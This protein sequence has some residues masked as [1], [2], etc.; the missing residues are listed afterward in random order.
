M[1]QTSSPDTL[2][3]LLENWPDEVTLVP[4]SGIQYLD[5]AFNIDTVMRGTM[6]FS[7]RVEPASE[8]QEIWRLW[9][10]TGNED[11]DAEIPPAKVEGEEDYSISKVRALEPFLNK[12]TP[13]P[14]L[15]LHLGRGP[16]GE[17]IYDG[18]PSTWAR[19]Y[20]TELAERDPKTAET[21]RVVLAIDTDLDEASDA[22]QPDTPYLM[23]TVKDAT[24]QR[25]FRLVCDAHR[26]A[27]FLRR[28]VTE[29]DGTKIDQQKWVDDW[30]RDQFL[31]LKRAQ[32]PGRDPRPEDFPYRFEHWARFLAMLR[33]L[34]HAIS[35]PKMK[36]LD[37]V[38]D[39]RRYQ[40]VD[41]DL[42]LDIG[43]SRTCG[44]LVE[45]YPDD[46][47]VDLNNSYVLAMR[48]LGRPELY[49]R[50]PFESS[51]EFAEAGFGPEH[52]ARRSGRSR[53]AFLWPSLVRVGP[54]ASRLVRG[55]HGTETVSGLSSPKRYLWDTQPVSQDWRFQGLSGGQQS[56]PTVARSAFRFVNE[57]GDVIE[58]V[59]NE[60]DRKLRK[61]GE[62]STSPAIRPRFSR[63]SLFT[64]MLAELIVHA[65]A[66]I[67][68]VAARATRKQS[69]LPRR[70]RNII[71]TLPSATPIQEQAIMRSR[72]EGAVRLAWSV[73]GWS[74]HKSPTCQMPNVVIDWDEA[75]CTQMVW[76]YDEIA[77]KFGGQ[78]EA[79]F[80]LKGSAR[81]RPDHLLPE[82]VQTSAPE[83][84]LRVGCIDIGGGTTD[85]MV[86]TYYSEDNRAIRPHQNVREGFR[87]AGDDLVR[88][89]V[90]RIV[91]PQLVDQMAEA[92]TQ[93]A[94]EL[95]RELF[96]GD[97]GDIEEQTRQRRRQ[98]ALQVLTPAALAVLEASETLQAGASR[99]LALAEIV[100]THPV[101]PG[102]DPEMP[103]PAKLLIPDDVIAFLHEPMQA[104]GCQNW[105]LADLSIDV[106][107]G[108]IEDIV[109]TSLGPALEA[110]LELVDHLVVDQ[111]LL[112]GR[113]SRLPYLRD[114]VRDSFAIRADRITSMHS[115]RVGGWYPY[116]DRISSRIGDPK[117][118]AAVGG[119]LCLLAANRIVN[120]KLHTEDIQMRSTARYIGEIERSGQ[121]LDE[122]VLFS[123]VDLGMGGSEEVAELRL[124]SPL[125]IGFRQLPHE[126]WMASPLYRLDFANE[127]AQRRPTP[128]K[129][130]LRRREI[131]GEAET[132]D[133]ILRAEALKEAFLIEEV[134][135][136][137]GGMC[138]A[139]DVKLTLHTLGV[140]EV[141]Y[142]LDSGTFRML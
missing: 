110:M 12:W 6:A 108:E 70:L 94:R 44:I 105:S 98:F 25:E 99:P 85:L 61:R 51:V 72:T 20:V 34:E 141:D 79:F 58:Q 117:T 47:R 109:R 136:A 71:M 19:L 86:T 140:D 9:P 54:E 3:A 102:H 2:R 14:V 132:S 11:K 126:R 59:K 81:R 142:W 89:V 95:I 92:G 62:T 88:E 7:E 33:L 26:M 124:R 13:V 23:P 16:N 116:R 106:R 60:E 128:F 129:V 10:H 65:L 45:S 55:S 69:D 1:T 4:Y 28:P 125:H 27:W 115:Y 29:A 64:F 31:D 53:P 130:T 40:C 82:G 101:P 80:K 49:Y 48:D 91:L 104:R 77:Q 52:I 74:A 114:F 123:G 139:S 83:P 24:D 87:I 5:F 63:S 56:M 22:G 8:D 97:V 43:N 66:Q 36:L 46:A 111:L 78:I 75:S 122:R 121:L 138:K 127:N 15:R 96:E 107:A 112:S 135:D 67:N 134:E 118:T 57:T 100:G 18:G 73:L 76:L 39:D 68:D 90:S 84:S 32:R 93:H 30:L 41:V 38:S 131:D 35:P 137:Q 17:E 50:R 119:M 133:E 103:V 37:T 21:H 42:V 113:P 120:F